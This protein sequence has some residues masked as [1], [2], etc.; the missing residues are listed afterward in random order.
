MYDTN[1][2]VSITR[3]LFIDNT[4]NSLEQSKF[5][6]GGGGIYIELTECRP[7]I[8]MCDHTSNQFNKFTNYTIHNC[9]FES[10]AVTYHLNGSDPD[11]LANGI[12]ITFGIGGGISLWLFGDAQ[13]N[14][15]QFR[16]T[17]F[18]FNS[19]HY[20][21]GINIHSKQDT[22]YNSI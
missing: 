7:G 11:D 9:V 12:F 8:I 1:G 4:L 5:F 2:S 22:K 3:S 20:G 14:S 6:T 21:G 10:N 19:A 17:I 13:N 18:T 16:S 15:F